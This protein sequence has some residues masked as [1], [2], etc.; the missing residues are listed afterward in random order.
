MTVGRFLTHTHAALACTLRRQASKPSLNN[1]AARCSS[2]SLPLT[3]RSPM[4]PG[5]YVNR[6]VSDVRDDRLCLAGVSR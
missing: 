2:R 6:F 5:R 3:R 4:A 1:R